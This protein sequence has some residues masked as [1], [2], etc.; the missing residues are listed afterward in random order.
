MYKYT[1]CAYTGMII[2]DEA[3]MTGMGQYNKCSIIGERS[4]PPSGLNGA[5]CLYNYIY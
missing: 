5:G 4:E 1:H 3:G 2:V